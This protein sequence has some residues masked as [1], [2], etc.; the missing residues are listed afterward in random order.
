[1]Q[2]DAA[3]LGASRRF[4]KIMSPSFSCV[5]LATKSFKF[6]TYA[7]RFFQTFQTQSHISEDRIHTLSA[8]SL[9]G[10]GSIPERSMCG[11]P[12]TRSFHSVPLTPYDLSN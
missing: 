1:M 4:G 10:P 3:S 8:V 5:Q 9:G 2:C 7:V 6:K 11:G 12:T